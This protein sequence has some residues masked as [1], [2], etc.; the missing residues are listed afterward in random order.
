[1]KSKTY[2]TVE[3]AALRSNRSERT[4]RRWIQKEYVRVDRDEQFH[5]VRV[6]QDDL[7]R[8]LAGRPDTS[9]PVRGEIAKLAT[10]DETLEQRISLLIQEV[11]RLQQRVE[12]L[13]SQDPG[14]E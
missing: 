12:V 8:I 3:E 1:M 4:I 10:N 7:D 5:S 11:A 2:I 9:H 6:D 13:E 14:S